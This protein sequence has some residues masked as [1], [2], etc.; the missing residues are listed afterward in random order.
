MV[1]V[2]IRVPVGSG[3]DSV[4]VRVVADAEP[5]F[6][7]A[8]ADGGDEHENWY[9][10]DVPVHNPITNYRVILDRGGAGYSWLNGSGEYSRDVADL[11]DFRLTVHAPGPDWALD[12]VVYQV[13]PDRFARSG[14]DRELPPGR[15]PA[16]WDDDRHPRRP[17]HPAAVLR[18]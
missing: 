13:F 15:S 17:G 14:A 3:V 5:T 11:H 9:T 2:R 7:P 18:R 10:A 6:V 12:S 8:V 4:F 1:P 16:D